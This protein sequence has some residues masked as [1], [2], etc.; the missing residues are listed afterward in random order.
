MLEDGYDIRTVQELLGHKNVATTYGLF[1]AAVGSD[2]VAYLAS[3]HIDGQSLREMI[4]KKR[5]KILHAELRDGFALTAPTKDLQRF[6]MKYADDPRA[7]SPHGDDGLELTLHR[8][9]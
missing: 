6:V 7:F 3:E 1:G 8:K 5:V 4:D 2:S 9:A